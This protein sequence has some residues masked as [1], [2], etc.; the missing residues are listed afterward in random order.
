M[1]LL[2]FLQSSAE[3][4]GQ[5]SYDILQPIRLRYFLSASERQ[6]DLKIGI[7]L[8]K[9]LN[10]SHFDADLHLNT[11]QNVSTT[12]GGPTNEKLHKYNFI[13]YFNFALE[14]GAMLSCDYSIPFRVIIF[15]SKYLEFLWFDFAHFWT[16]AR[17]NSYL[18][19]M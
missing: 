16:H 14:V 1:R 3:E 9:H 12:I 6:V 19:F 5:M 4:V 2:Y 10:L 13:Y 7:G 11:T 15:K 18:S 8:K 17:S